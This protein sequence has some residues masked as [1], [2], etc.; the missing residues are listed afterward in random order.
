M[1]NVNIFSIFFL[2]L[3]MLAGAAVYQFFKGRRKNLMILEKSIGVFEKVFRPIDKKYTIIGVYV[4]YSGKY[5]VSD[6]LIKNIN[7]LALTFPRQ[8]LFYAPIA[9]LTSRYDRFYIA[10]DYE[11]DKSIPGEAHLIRKGYY[12]LGIRR[13]IKGIEKMR[14]EKIII[15]GKTYYLAYT[16]R[17]LM[18]KIINYVKNLEDPKLIDHIALIRKPK[19]LFLAARLDIDKLYKVVEGFYH[20]SKII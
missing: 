14:V 8:S 7:V 9:K 20:L 2:L 11:N 3:I 12:R 18:E 4:G 13:T 15:M 6:P 5:Q 19:R 17:Y 16:N 1:D 10:I